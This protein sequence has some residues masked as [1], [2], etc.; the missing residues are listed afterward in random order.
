[1]HKLPGDE[2]KYIVLGFGAG[3]LIKNLAVSFLSLA[4]VAVVE[5]AASANAHSGWAREIGTTV[6]RTNQW[7]WQTL[8]CWLGRSWRSMTLSQLMSYLPESS[9]I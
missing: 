4:N 5:E 3:A 9:R 1:M 2:R 8:R 7:K 6:L